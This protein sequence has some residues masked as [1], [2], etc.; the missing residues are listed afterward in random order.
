[1]PL[2]LLGI[3]LPMTNTINAVVDTYI[4]SWNEG[5]EA[6]RRELVAQAFTADA[7]YVDPLMAGEGTDGITAMIGAAQ[8]QF[9]G[10]RFEL[11][12][13][14][15]AHNDVVRFA[16][17]LVGDNGPVAGGTDFATVADDGRLRNV[18]G[19]L[20]TAEA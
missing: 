18:T 1:M 12:F 17:R 9:P 3:V 13:G 2:P 20:E 11:A 14:P 15:D 10:H 16:W 4:A 6:R 5:N 19:F 8:T 7:R